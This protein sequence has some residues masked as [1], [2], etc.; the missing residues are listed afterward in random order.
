MNDCLAVAR[1]NRA[2][3]PGAGRF[4]DYKILNHLLA[5]CIQVVS[6]K[7]GS[8][9]VESRFRQPASPLLTGGD[10]SQQKFK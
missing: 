8:Q 7:F 5:D 4:V 1:W 10:S 6:A 3:T 2:P 9:A